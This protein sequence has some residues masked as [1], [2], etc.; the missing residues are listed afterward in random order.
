ML[1]P[2]AQPERDV[3]AALRRA[4]AELGDIFRLPLGKR[5]VTFICS[6]ALAYQVLIAQR[7]RFR[8]LGGAPPSGLERLL[9]PS[10]LTEVA[11]E[12]WQP[13]RRR[14]QP[15]FNRRQLAPLAEVIDRHAAALA[16]RWAA[17]P[18]GALVRVDA[19]LMQ[20]VYDVMMQLVFSA[21]PDGSQVL[22]VPLALATARASQLKV[23]REQLIAELQA[24]LAARRRLAAPPQDLLQLLLAAPLD[25]DARISELLTV[26]AA[27]HETT[28]SAL[29]F[30]LYELACYPAAQR[31]LREALAAS[32]SPPYLR[33]VIQETLRLYPTIPQAP[34][35]ATERLTLAGYE[36]TKGARVVV[37]IY[38]IHRN[39]RAWQDPDAFI[40]ERFLAPLPPYDYLPYGLGER[41][42]LGRHLAQLVLE[43]T[44]AQLLRRLQ[45][46]AGPEMKLKV[47]IGLTPDVGVNLRV[48][49]ALQKIS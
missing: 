41:S 44:L 26:F 43:R 25:D 8:K 40:P 47:A 23:R 4:H 49:P 10:V 20:L 36:V 1:P 32:D 19:A 37:S 45:F 42:C 15:A 3:L 17:L 22:A 12:R 9:G 46:A 34:R 27:G 2:Q 21:A 31:R 38:R 7:Q 18:P 11:R 30:A 33:A 5:E 24:R 29:A 48:A 13:R 16:E 39:P 6:G 35:V 14:L 28:A